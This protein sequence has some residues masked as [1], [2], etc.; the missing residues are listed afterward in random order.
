[1]AEINNAAGGE[2]ISVKPSFNIESPLTGLRGIVR[3]PAVRRAIPA[4]GAVS[5]LAL[6]GLAWWSLQSPNQ[7]PLFGGLSETDKAAVANALQ[8]SGMAYSLD[9]DTGALTVSEDEV[10]SARMLLA[11]Q[12]LPKALPGG[13]T[14]LAAVPMGSSRA[15]EGEA[16]RSSREADLARTIEAVEAVK[17]ARVHLA[18]P[19]PSLFVRETAQPAASIMLTL[20]SGRTLS[21]AQVRAIRHLVA[22]SVPGLSPDQ[23]SIIDQSGSLLSQTGSGG[24]DA[25]F[26]LQLQME[27]RYRQ[28]INTL[29]TPIVG[30]GNFAAELHVDVDQSESQSTRET[31]P[32]DDRALRQEEGNK[33][34]T[35]TVNQS[36][37]GIPGA[38]S[39]TPPPASQLSAGPASP[40]G[41][42]RGGD[43][44]SEETYTRRFDVG[45]EISVT[46]QGVGKVRRLTVG[47]ALRDVP[48]AKKRSASELA[49]L[50][51]LV[52][53][54]VGF[55]AARGDVVALSARPFKAEDAS[56]V[57][58][59]D[60]PW[61]L[62]ALRQGGALLAGLLILIFIGRPV[63]KSLSAKAAD[64]SPYQGGNQSSSL[65][66][67]DVTLDM[68]EAAPRYAD[69][70]TLVRDF[71]KQNPERTNIVVQQLVKEGSDA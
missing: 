16:L 57:A 10:H 43:S 42:A 37:I 18:T 9:R 70:A 34:S 11:S 13:D 55:D 15:V 25:A 31:Y 52:K 49:S 33:T 62:V 61:F 53:G 60:Q 51:L 40:T 66:G 23:V 5:V 58:L 54:A 30:A 38:L 35:A 67:G 4:M 12:G 14:V 29:M 71:V 32:K 63:L 47:V 69:R 56:A 39:N 44:Q 21:E 41:T 46:H 26:Q 48:G 7:V 20:Q 65:A 6:A 28:A 3:Q 64:Q 24:D 19:E 68:I 27:N 59:W 2:I 50:E 36:A 17:S 1:M 8:A 45:R 22:S